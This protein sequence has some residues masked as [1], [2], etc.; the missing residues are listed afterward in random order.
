MSFA[1]KW[2]Q[3]R[4]QNF[5]C[6]DV[7]AITQKK[8]MS[9]IKNCK[10]DGAKLLHLNIQQVKFLCSS[11]DIPKET[12]TFGGVN[13]TE[14]GQQKPLQED[15]MKLNN[16]TMARPFLDGMPSMLERKEEN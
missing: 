15:N 9:I 5:L 1:L 11:K 8:L 13:Q 3:A 14:F 4:V 12:T 6:K 2:T 10:I 7:R 16:A